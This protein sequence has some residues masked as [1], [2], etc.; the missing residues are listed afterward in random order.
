MFLRFGGGGGGGRMGYNE[1]YA[2]YTM[3]KNDTHTLISPQPWPAQA[4]STAETS[5]LTTPT[6]RFVWAWTWVEIKGFFLQMWKGGSMM[7]MMMV[8]AKTCWPRKEK[9]P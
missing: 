7:M 6:R 3:M 4:V 8:S 5:S 1:T 9:A 2:K